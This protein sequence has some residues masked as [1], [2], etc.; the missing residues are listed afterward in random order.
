MKVYRSFDNVPYFK[1]TILTVGTFDGVHLGHQFIIN[2]LLN[3][4]IK[5]N[6]RTMILTI[7][8]HP[9]LIIKPKDGKEIKLLTDINERIT[10]FERFG[11]ENLVIIP[12]DYNFS[13]TSPE[14]FVRNYLNKIGFSKIL[15]GHD[16]MFGRDREGNEDLLKALSGELNF[17]IEKFDALTIN[18]I[19]ISSTKI[20]N[21]LSEG[22]LEDAKL[23]L[24]YNYFVRG[25]IIKGDNRGASLGFPTANFQISK[26]KQLPR[27]GVYLVKSIIDNNTV[28]GMA[29][30]GFKPTFKDDRKLTFEVHY[31]NFDGNL[32]N[33]VLVVEFLSYLREEKKF[34]SINELVIQLEND[35]KKSLKMINS[36]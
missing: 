25:K 19:T 7:D 2:K 5:N 16:H 6:L 27:N 21:A 28:Y 1:N 24:G 35:K 4:G 32:Y 10:L 20:R 13:R 9:R 23:M 26:N 3:D 30:I 29:N 31:L 33:E 11:V 34:E 15:I 36:F 22:K 12:F 17:E 14:D 18:N 8:P